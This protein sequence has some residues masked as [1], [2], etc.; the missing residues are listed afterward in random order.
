[1]AELRLETARLILREWRAGDVAPFQAICSDPV[2]MAT[3]GPPLDMTQTQALIA[4][5]RT[6]QGERG[7]CFW[8]LERRD[9]ERLIGWCGAIRG[10]VGPVDGKAEIGWRLASDCWGSGY[11]T[12]AASATLDWLFT[13]PADRNAWAITHTG[14]HR[15]RAVM[16]RLGMVRHPDLNFDHPALAADDPLRPHVTYSITADQWRTRA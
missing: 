3:L 8:A 14:N 9:D 13:A 15:S 7:H 6:M 16:E 10:S 4:R 11:A 2:V 12:E 5:M 1:M